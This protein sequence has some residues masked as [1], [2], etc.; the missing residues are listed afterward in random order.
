MVDSNAND[1][2]SVSFGCFGWVTKTIK[3]TLIIGNI[4]NPR[5]MIFLFNMEGWNWSRCDVRH[6]WLFLVHQWIWG[7]NHLQYFW[8]P[9]N[10]QQNYIIQNTGGLPVLRN[11]HFNHCHCSTGGRSIWTASGRN[12]ST[13]AGVEV[14]RFDVMEWWKLGDKTSQ[15]FQHLVFRKRIYSIIYLC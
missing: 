3:W 5:K 9:K 14:H 13:G 7:W 11:L 2:M 6:E 8:A 12:G 1:Q 15:N 4:W 10:R